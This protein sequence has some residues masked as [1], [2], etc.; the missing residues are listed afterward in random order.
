M[1]TSGLF[2]FVG[3]KKRRIGSFGGAPPT[4]WVRVGDD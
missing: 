4:D 3:M 2:W 1:N